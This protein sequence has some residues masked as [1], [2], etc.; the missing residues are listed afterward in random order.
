[1]FKSTSFPSKS[2]LYCACG[3]LKTTSLHHKCRCVCE[4]TEKLVTAE[5]VAK[6]FTL[7]QVVTLP[8]HIAHVEITI[9]MV[10]ITGSAHGSKRIGLMII[11]I[12]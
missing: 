8:S 5:L 3:A 10:N 1:M 9:V 7:Q 11:E 4:A 2:A 12:H 6:L